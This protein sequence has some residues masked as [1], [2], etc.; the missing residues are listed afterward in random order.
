[1]LLCLFDLVFEAADEFV[2]FEGIELR[3]TLDLDLG[4]PDD[5]L[6]G[7]FAEKHAEVRAEALPDLFDD[8]FPGFAFLDAS[9]DPL[10]DEDF[11][12]TGKMPLLLEFSQLDFEFLLE[13][14]PGLLGAVLENLADPEKAGLVVLNN[15]GVGGDADL[16]VG[17]GIEC[18]EGLVGVDSCGKIDMD[19]DILC[20][21]VLKSR[22]SD[23]A[24]LVRFEDGVAEAGRG[25][26]E[27]DL[28][29][30]ELAGFAPFDTSPDTDSPSTET[31]VVIRHIGD[32]ALNEVRK[33]F[34]LLFS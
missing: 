25:R 29:D 3:D 8:R 7:D 19:L 1:M 30:H 27:R 16:A 21:A 20:G 18:L 23:L 2:G 15:A 11:F 32:P 14:F 9:I 17:E 22:D 34:E 12:E 4:E 10:L 5:V 6:L 13:E 26:S 24:L 31:V 33:N 28:P